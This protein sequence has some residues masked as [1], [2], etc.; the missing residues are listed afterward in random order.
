MSI[1]GGPGRGPVTGDTSPYVGGTNE[2][3]GV[4]RMFILKAP[5]SSPL[6][7]W[8]TSVRQKGG[9]PGQAVVT[10]A[11]ESALAAGPSARVLHNVENNISLPGN[12][13]SGGDL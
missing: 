6:R 9:L 8:L 7:G 13:D 12:E 3:E 2:P 10:V 11:S 4:C 5:R 1:I